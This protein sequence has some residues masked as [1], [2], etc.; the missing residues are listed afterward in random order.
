[1][2]YYRI[3]ISVIVI[4]LTLLTSI[5]FNIKIYFQIRETSFLLF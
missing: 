1:M 5:N 2:N 3:Y 4:L